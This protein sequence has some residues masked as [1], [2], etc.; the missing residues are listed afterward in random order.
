MLSSNLPAPYEIVMPNGHKRTLYRDFNGRFIPK[1]KYLRLN[2]ANA[3][4][5]MSSVSDTR[6]RTGD[7]DRNVFG[8]RENI[9]GDKVDGDKV[10]GDKVDG[11]KV[12]G[13]KTV[14]NQTVVL[15]PRSCNNYKDDNGAL[16]Q[17]IEMT[18]EQARGLGRIPRYECLDLKDNDLSS[19]DLKNCVFYR[20]KLVR[21]DLSESYLDGSDLSRIILRNAKLKNT[22]CK[23]AHF[24]HGDLHAIS[25]AKAVFRNAKLC[26]AILDWADLSGADLRGS[27]LN[28][29]RTKHTVLD[30]V[31]FDDTTT[32]D[33]NLIIILGASK[34][35][36]DDMAL[37][38][39]V[40]EN[41]RILDGRFACHDLAGAKLR[42]ASLVRADMYAANMRGI[43]MEEAVLIEA[44]LRH[45]QLQYACLGSACLSKADLRHA[46]LS[47]ADLSN[48]DLSD[49]NLSFVD[50]ENTDLSR[51]N[52]TRANLRGAQHLTKAQLDS[53]RSLS[54]A[55]LPDGSI[56]RQG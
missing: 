27:N 28:G 50:L 22:S 31:I 43:I 1:S 49:A 26:N 23:D 24:E 44:N 7:P 33:P 41:Q 16:R 10:A 45:A 51:A 18:R 13:D 3:A 2:Q 38:N 14:Y 48:A 53:V 20:S 11:D 46:D 39:G 35:E 21:C 34:G 32:F 37:R 5:S 12:N 30:N 56:H 55:T 36:L 6:S 42:G 47:H 15:E 25:A 40:Y 52:L 17:C 9:V 8:Y 19:L 4:E 29:V 54:G